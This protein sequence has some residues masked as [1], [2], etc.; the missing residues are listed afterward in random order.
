M[1]LNFERSF[2]SNRNVSEKINSISE[3]PTKIKGSF[4]FYQVSDAP[5]RKFRVRLRTCMS[6]RT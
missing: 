3:N 2:N 4:D 6:E 5:H 1:N